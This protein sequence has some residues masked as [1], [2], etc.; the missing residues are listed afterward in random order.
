MRGLTVRWSLA[1][2]PDESLDELRDYVA[3]VSHGRFSEYPGLRFKTW[4]ARPG[5]WFEGC[6]VFADA[7]GRADFQDTFAAGAADS[8]VSKILGRPPVLIEPCDVIAV[9]EGAAGFKP[10]PRLD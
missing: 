7:D 9:A 1:E 4:R 10:S 3:D 2:T 5:E 8:P 6:Y